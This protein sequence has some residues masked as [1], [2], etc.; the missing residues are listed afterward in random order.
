MKKESIAILLVSLGLIGAMAGL[1]GYRKAH[2]RLGVPGVNVV[3]VPVHD[4][5]GK[6]A[7]TNSVHLP[8]KVL[9]YTSEVVPLEKIVLDW[10]PKDTVYGQRTYKSPDGAQVAMTVVLMGADR[11]SI[12]KP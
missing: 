3:N 2:Q 8:E 9:N 4:V 1:I 6:V 5:D 11:T 10:L 7:G 12:H